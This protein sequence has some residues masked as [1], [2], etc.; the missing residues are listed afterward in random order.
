MGRCS[1]D[2]TAVRQAIRTRHWV[3][4]VHNNDGY[5]IRDYGDM[6]ADR[7]RTDAFVAALERQI[8]VD[9]VVLEIG[10]GVG[11]FAFVAVQAGAARVYAVEPDN[12]IEVARLCARDIPG[13]ERIRWIQ[14]LSTGLDLP[15]KVDI[16]IGDLHGTL[17]FYNNNIGSLIDA[18]QR[19]L[20]PA[21][22]II[23]A[24]DVLRMVPAQ[25]ADEYARVQ[26]PWSS[27]PH[28]LN[29]G[30][31]RG[32]VAN[33]WW[34]A[35]KKPVPSEQLL[36]SPVTWGVVDY[37]TVETASVDAE[38]AWTIE[39]AGT[40]HGYYVW[41]DGELAEGVGY[42][43]APDLPELVYGRAFFPLEQP[44]ELVIGDSIETRMSTRL[45]KGEQIYRWDTRIHDASGNIKASFKQSTLRG[46]PLNPRELK[47]TTAGHV[48]R[49]NVEGQVAQAVIAGM[50][51]S[52]SLGQIAD[53]LVA[54]FP[55][56][57]NDV[58]EALGHATRLSLK[59]SDPA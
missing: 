36:A 43:N 23:P 21:G 7:I 46:T 25:A 41:F 16:V 35:R 19:H 4:R 22:A 14:G 37:M 56:R 49:L 8:S 34:R 10:T 44:V 5:S 53:L 55:R 39:R 24:R 15:E 13:S 27:N 32:F 30:A 33:Q 1:S 6:L 45:V 57:F 29:L 40:M 47:R 51:Q 58:A 48:P 26:T 50:A 52:L 18:R 3:E 31:G 17:P 2:A 11:Y 38:L 9:S 12:A 42:S 20:K 54:Q 59:Y 28:G